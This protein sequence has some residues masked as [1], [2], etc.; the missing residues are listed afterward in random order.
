M[1]ID[2]K[3]EINRL[4]NLARD[5]K[6]DEYMGRK[7]DMRLARLV[8]AHRKTAMMSQEDM[9]RRVGFPLERIKSLEE[10]DK[11]CLCGLADS[12]YPLSFSVNIHR[13]PLRGRLVFLF[14]FPR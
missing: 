8:R 4:E 2:Y 12:R 13:D 3:A 9:A 7:V 5:G 10:G 14:S 11:R 1:S 6:V